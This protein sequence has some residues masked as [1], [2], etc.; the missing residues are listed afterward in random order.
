M[1]ENMENVVMTEDA[2][3]DVMSTESN[4]GGK[5]GKGLLIGGAVVGLVVLARKAVKKIKAKRAAKKTQQADV[6]GV[7]YEEVACEAE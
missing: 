2:M 6:V 7:E 1:N 3:G 5:I 4:L